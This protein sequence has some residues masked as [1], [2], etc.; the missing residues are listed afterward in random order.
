MTTGKTDSQS[1]RDPHRKNDCP[2]SRI[3]FQTVFAAPETPVRQ[4]Y[5]VFDE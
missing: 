3:R 5:A 2:E 4:I 1:Y